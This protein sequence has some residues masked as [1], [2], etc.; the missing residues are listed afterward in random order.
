[1][2]DLSGHDERP[3]HL[4][5]GFLLRRGEQDRLK[6]RQRVKSRLHQGEEVRGGCEHRKASRA[7]SGCAVVVGCGPARRGAQDLDG[8]NLRREGLRTGVN[9]LAAS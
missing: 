2:R 9:G 5:R 4:G 1:M 6:R 3:L 8:W 7:D